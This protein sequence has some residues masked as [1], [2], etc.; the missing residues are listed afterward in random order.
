[1]RTGR[2]TR[3]VLPEAGAA[4]AAGPLTLGAP[5]FPAPPG[6][7]APVASAIQRGMWLASRMD[8]GSSAFNVP[9]ATLLTGPLDVSALQ[10]AV[11]A[12]VARHPILRTRFERTPGDAVVPVVDPACRVTVETADAGAE[13][14]AE[15]Y[16]RAR[17]CVEEAAH[18]PFDLGRAPLLRVLLIR[19]GQGEHVLFL[20]LHHAVCD[21][22]SVRLLLD[23]L[24]GGYRAAVDGRTPPSAPP[25]AGYAGYAAD[26]A[27]LL[28]GGGFA[29]DVAYWRERLRGVRALP[30][31]RG[32]AGGRRDSEGAG[33]RFTLDAELVARVDAF[34]RRTGT[35]RYVVLLSAFS[36]VLGRL[37]GTA[38]VP[39]GTTV[40]TRFSDESADMIGPLFNTLV[41]RQDA[42][43]DTTF[44][45]L[46]AGAKEVVLQAFEHHE[47]PFEHVLEHLRADAP[48]SGR[49]PLF[50][51]FFELDHEAERP[52]ALPGLRSRL[53]AFDHFAVKTDLMVSLSPDGD[54]LRGLLLHHPEAFDAELA[55]ILTERYRA[56]LLEATSLPDAPLSALS[57][58]SDAERVAVRD[59][60]PDGGPAELPDVCA[61][62]LFEAQARRTPHA[63]A[64]RELADGAPG[65][66]FAELDARANR[67]ARALRAR[68]VGPESRVAVLLP[69]SADLLVAFLAVWKAGGA[70][71]PL[72]PAFP[73]ARLSFLVQ[74]SAA[75]LVVS[76]GGLEARAGELGAP[77]VPVEVPG[78]DAALPPAAAPGGLCYIIYTS[79][80]TGQPKGVL[81]E[82][83]GLVN[84]L[85]WCVR[86]Y[87]SHGD[88]GAALFS[89]VAFDMVVPNLFTPL[90]TG[91]TVHVVPDDVPADR[92]G[93]VLASAAPYGFLKMT[94]GHL[95][96]LTRQLT[97]GEARGLAAKLVV[98]ADAFPESV[99]AAWR[100]LD[101]GT[102]MLNEY[103]PTEA[104]VANCVHEIGA[105]LPGGSG[106]LPIGRPI[107][108]TTMYVLDRHGAPAPVGVIGELYIGG[109][110]V[111]RGY[112]NRPATTAAS[113]VPDPF[114]PPGA[115]MYRTGDLGRW[116][117]SGE[118]EFLGRVDHQVK[119]RGYR[120]EPAEVEAALTAHPSVSQALVTVARTP[121]GHDAL[122]AYVVPRGPEGVDA[123]ALRRDAAL[124]LPAYL[125]PATVVAV[126]AVPLNQ[127][128]KVDRSALPEPVWGGEGGA[129]DSERP[130]SELE[131]TVADLWSR[132][133]GIPAT[134]LG[135]HDNFFELGGNSLLVLSIGERIRE[136]FGTGVS[137]ERFFESPTIA[138][139]SASLALALGPKSAPRAGCLKLLDGGGDATPMVFVHPLGG[140][141]FC[142]RDLIDDLRGE[143]PLYGLTLASLLGEED[144]EQ[145]L[146]EMAGRYAEEIERSISGPVVVTGW[147]AGGVIA[148]ETARRL[149]ERGVQ[150]DLLA[151]LDPSAPSERSRWRGHTREL[152]QIR[153]RLSLA[154]EGER[155]AEFQS[156]VR[157]ELFR[158]MGI[159]PSTCREYS[160]FPQEVFDIWQRQLG[161]LG[162]YEPDVYDGPVAVLTSEQ[163]DAPAQAAV[164]R[165]WQELAADPVRHLHVQGDHLSMM[166]PPAVAS[167]ASALRLLRD[168]APR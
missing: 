165:D 167:V 144:G 103:G 137:V 48:G 102:P 128:G 139:V 86:D 108:N 43:G 104:S 150:V 163:L 131:R 130:A 8:P 75:A 53:F 142:Y 14:A 124:R 117:P 123:D 88:G 91:Q 65:M 26:E 146:E 50:N 23:E 161:L 112:A 111:V 154:T 143:G 166:R 153:S 87:A 95:E 28:A 15:A 27:G 17:A 109:A 97:A 42:G 148:F 36:A 2:M 39:V 54:G 145:S 62:E 72:D 63:V 33:L 22:W 99:L 60:L 106:T 149:R 98:G 157:S 37:C 129:P 100:R 133:L 38:D 82:H 85:M 74:D 57:M 6:R 40:A 155:E 159:D 20:N 24:A 136:R 4:P 89:S 81:V 45:E 47:A 59:R 140:T 134:R 79:G 34:A 151:L 18:T 71:V 107:P 141:V 90:L 92:L 160:L 5:G 126:G 110:C 31:P 49:N 121:S 83:R 9:T 58:M 120:V 94:P 96:L 158:A 114:G 19:V 116:L 125:V 115:R 147:S 46:V 16:R 105:S 76:G 164:A 70:Y 64:V 32:H 93:A 10:A 68:G 80:S 13:T 30:L 44:G 29:E 67:L 127:N 51:V 21:G 77:V 152:R 132:V 101:P 25:P 118:L 168:R 119:V 3:E 56:T 162:A 73:P 156:A 78:D 135:R 66:T 1:M 113:F 61:H 84:F 122:V 41:L 11:D 55:T 12:V 7:A 138:D 69:R 35:T 52:L